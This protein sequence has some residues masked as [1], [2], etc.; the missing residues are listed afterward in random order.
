[1]YYKAITMGDRKRASQILAA[2]SPKDAKALGRQIANFD[3]EL[4]TLKREE[5]MA[6]G[7]RLKA[8]QHPLIKMTLLGTCGKVLVEASPY[9]L[10][11]GIGCSKD[12]PRAA[13]EC[14]WPGQNL[15]GKAWTKVREILLLD[16][17]Q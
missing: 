17:P 16:M 4:W 12:D 6:E 9:D 13:S 10:T 11:W 8:Q 15:L 14:D 2:K 7:L 1:M 3:D 5:I